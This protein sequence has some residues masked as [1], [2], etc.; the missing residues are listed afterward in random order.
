MPATSRSGECFRLRSEN[1]RAG[2]PSKS[3]MRKSFFSSSTCP[4]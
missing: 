2:S 4:R 1:G 3:M